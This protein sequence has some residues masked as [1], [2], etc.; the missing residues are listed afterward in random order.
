MY[1]KILIGNDGSEGAARAL[2]VALEL[3]KRLGAALHMISV[4]E[5]PRF[6]TSIDE[7]IEDRADIGYQYKRVIGRART[8]ALAQEIDLHVHFVA[9]HAV[10]SIV[11]F[12]GREKVDLLLVGYMG[13]T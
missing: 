2:M 6:A 11:D 5:M 7:V 1:R 8:Q 4:E 10:P 9:G 13:H 12:V 3:T